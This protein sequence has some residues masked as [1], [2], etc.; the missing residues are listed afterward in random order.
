MEFRFGFL[1]ADFYLGLV[2][3]GGIGFKVL[4]FL[5]GVGILGFRE[6]ICIFGFI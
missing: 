2:G 6:Y 1:K 3:N 5:W 4:L